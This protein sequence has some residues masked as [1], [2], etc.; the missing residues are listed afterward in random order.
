MFIYRESLEFRCLLVDN[1]LLDVLFESFHVFT[2][3][4]HISTSDHQIYQIILDQCALP[5]PLSYF[6]KYFLHLSQN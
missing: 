6:V 5:F 1:I 4:Q 3:H 2:S